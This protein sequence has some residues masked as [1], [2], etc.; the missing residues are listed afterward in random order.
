[1]T[2]GWSQDS[3]SGTK[4][5]YRGIAAGTTLICIGTILLLNTLGRL[6]WGVWFDLVRFWPLLLISAGLRLLFANTRLH[7]LSLLGP[8]M[9][10]GMTIYVAM[11][12]EGRT[13]DHFDEMA[14]S[15]P[16]DLACPAKAGVDHTRVHVDFAA[17]RLRLNEVGAPQTQAAAVPAK[18]GFTGSLR[19]EGIAPR[20]TCGSAGDIGL[21][22]GFMDHGVHFLLPMKD[23]DVVW[24]ASLSSTLPVA[25]DLEL[26]AAWADLDL[27]P[28][29]LSYFDLETAASRAVI[30]LGP[31]KGR[32]PVRVS[33]GVGAVRLVVPTGTCFTVTRN[34]IL[35][36]LDVDE[37]L[38]NTRRARNV[39]ASACTGLKPDA[40]RYEIRY[41]VPLSHVSVETEAA[42]I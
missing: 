16:I 1:M 11:N 37:P 33:G 13:F 29:A 10:V 3:R 4:R 17:G 42:G 18:Q 15:E 24:D 34:R 7:A 2:S 20:F 32:I 26:K 9:I 14:L 5:P 21:R 30:H 6:P 12:Y 25:V 38:E 39:T 36:I 19:Y 28:L 22:R 23:D 35:N 40:P 31:P 41:D 8:A 27:R